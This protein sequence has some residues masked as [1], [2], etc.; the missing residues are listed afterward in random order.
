MN[1][2][3]STAVRSD[4]RDRAIAVGIHEP[5]VVALLDGAPAAWWS[6]P[7]DDLMADLV[8]LAPGLLPGQV[9]LRISA[10]T[11]GQLWDLSLVA[12]D[13]RGLLATT[14]SVC[15]AHGMSIR[16]GRAATWPGLGLQRM[17]I[18]PQVVPLSGE[19]DWT[20]LGQAL[21]SALCDADPGQPNGAPEHL[22]THETVD[23]SI[24]TIE[25][26][27]DA[28][29]KVSITAVSQ[30][31]L[32]AAITRALTTAG[33]DIR[34]AEFVDHDGV[35]SDVFVVSGLNPELLSVKTT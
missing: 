23:F 34:S 24:D 10:P 26:L 16:S 3:Q 33:A 25:K 17:Q 19:P 28:M 9:R 21:R 8:L 31:G 6:A 32:L 27:P 2:M 22:V 15:A 20:P 5:I 11:E 7:F 30:I 12:P 29:M 4:L 14:A 13:R 1:A 35:I 18:E